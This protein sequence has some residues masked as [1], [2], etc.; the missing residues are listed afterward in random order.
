LDPQNLQKLTVLLIE[1]NPD[2]A[3]IV[4]HW[5]SQSGQEIEFLLNWTDSL[6]ESRRRLSRG[7]VAVILL[8]LN[9]PDSEG[10]ATFTAVRAQ[11]PDTPVII[12]SA[13]DDVA[14]ALQLIQE[15]ADNYLVKSSCTAEALT[16]AIRFALVKQ[17]LNA[18][19][20]Q[21]VDEVLDQATVVAVTGGKGGVGTTTVACTLAA[22][23]RRRT[24]ESI[25][26]A[27]LDIYTG[28]VAFLMAVEAQYSVIDALS[29]STR[30]DRSLWQRL[31]AQ[32]EE[33]IDVLCAP[34]IAGSINGLPERLCQVLSAVRP[35][36]RW[37]VLDLGRLN[38][39]ASEV[40]DA[41]DE[42]VVV[43]TTSIPALYET[44]R[45][46]ETLRGAGL[47][48]RIRLTVNRV[49]A[50]EG[51]SPKDVR[52]IFGIE[53][54]AVLSSST[55]ELNEA[56]VQKKLPG[57]D[58]DFSKSM[59]KLVQAVGGPQDAEPRKPSLAERL[60]LGRKSLSQFASKNP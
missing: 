3:K 54:S 5:L 6:A 8:D 20:R 26:L 18:R 53:V 38:S 56:Y 9:L 46:I 28:L 4:Q 57:K 37:I 1:D 35:F 19:R 52:S 49:E 43:T 59:A 23:L 47:S 60:R 44:K 14:L 58:S 39:C 10:I 55:R 33:G 51:C 48:D 17:D 31:V 12:L 40:L 13:G 11:A 24:G 25:L 34:S 27:D 41:A 7:N 42:H 29:N 32:S 22:E 21:R 30:L 2:F 45:A 15:G 50:L 16:R 36:Y